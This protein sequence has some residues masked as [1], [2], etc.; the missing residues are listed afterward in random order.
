MSYTH[1]NGF[2]FASAFEIKLTNTVYIQSSLFRYTS[3][4]VIYN[5]Q[6]E[7]IHSSSI[8]FIVEIVMSNR[9]KKKKQEIEIKRR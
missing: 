1:Y 4:E 8:E 9:K 5:C 3:V 7:A 2:L 6:S